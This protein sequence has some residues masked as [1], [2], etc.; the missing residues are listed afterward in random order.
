MLSVEFRFPGERPNSSSSSSTTREPKQ[1]QRRHLASTTVSNEVL[2]SSYYDQVNNGRNRGEAALLVHVLTNK[3]KNVSSMTG[4]GPY[5]PHHYHH[6]HN[7][8]DDP[9]G[10]QQS[11]VDML[12]K[13]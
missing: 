10:F 13:S 12:G 7:H 11:L 8:L 2:P 9:R 3:L 4:A 6:H 5:D 1:Q